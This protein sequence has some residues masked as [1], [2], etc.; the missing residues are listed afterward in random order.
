MN[1][2]NTKRKSP[3]VDA[4]QGTCDKVLDLFSNISIPLGGRGDHK[5]WSV[6]SSLAAREADRGCVWSC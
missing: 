6:R 5:L 2:A 4:N 1:D 3:E